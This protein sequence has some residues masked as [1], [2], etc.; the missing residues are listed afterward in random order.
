MPANCDAIVQI[1]DTKLVKEDMGVEK[2]VDILIEPKKGLDIRWELLL[3]ISQIR[4]RSF[5][6]PLTDTV[7]SHVSLTFKIDLYL[8]RLEFISS[9]FV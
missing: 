6:R 1:E 4:K 7:V 2:E 3:T 8:K 5:I 9:F